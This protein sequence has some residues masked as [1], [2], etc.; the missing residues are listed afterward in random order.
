M[1]PFPLNLHSERYGATGNIGENFRRL[2]GAPALDPLQTVIREAVQNICDAAKLGRGPEIL[3]RLRNL[4]KAEKGI[5]TTRVLAE[6]PRADGSSRR[7]EETLRKTDIPVLEICDFNTTGLGGPTRSDRIPIG[8]TRRDFIDFVRNIGTPRDTDLGGGTYGFGKVSLYVASRCSTILVDTLPEGAGPD[9]RRFIGCHVGNSFTVPED[10]MSRSFTGRHWWGR[11]DPED[12][13]ADPVTGFEA[14]ALADGLGFP[15]RVPGS[16][17]T[18]IMILDFE[19]ENEDLD[20]LGRRIVESLLYN[21]WPRMMQDT[22]EARRFTCRVEVGNVLIE[23]PSPEDFPPLDLYCK[24]MR[25]ALGREGNDVREIRSQKP[26]RSLGTLTLE[27]GLRAQRRPLVAEG[28][29]FPDIAHHIALMRPVELVVKYLEGTALPD[30]RLEWAGVFIT[31]S[32]REVERAFAD[33]EP[34][35]HDDWVPNNLPKGNAKR[36][37]NV[38]LRQL[39][40]IALEQG[41]PSQGQAGVHEAEG[42]SLARLAGRLG[43][44]LEDVGGDGA[45]PGGRAGGRGG[46]PPRRARVTRPLF[47][48]LEYTDAGTT[49]IFTADVAQDASRTGK[50]LEASAS[51]AIDG[52]AAGS[53]DSG[54][55]EDGIELPRLISIA[56][57]DGSL[58][59]SGARLVLDGAEGRFQFRVFV[60]GNCAVTLDARI[61][62]EDGS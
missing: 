60:P 41:A 17:G 23:I 49:A 25:A 48:C 3:I 43:A 7:L 54:D 44:V 12:C 52:G 42:T 57:E 30:E 5:L 28:S 24:A 58:E 46:R 35:A 32:E 36:Y 11:L 16:E 19:T 21:F 59:V 62:Q 13:V 18:T 9:G 15:G 33:S 39:K 8:T 26:A 61:L 20:N 51:I 45:G 10:G 22:L 47:K 27:R 1:N 31:S 37:V 53:V 50:L 38:A 34:P 14:T 4:D 56:A 6:L 55:I 40:T 2:L 29:L